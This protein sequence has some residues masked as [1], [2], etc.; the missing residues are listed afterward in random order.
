MASETAPGA[1]YEALLALC[2]R[3]RSVRRF[4]P[5]P[6]PEETV[7]RIL[8]VAR[9]S[10]Y[11]AGKKSWSVK[12]VR[13]PSVLEAMAMAVRRRVEL[14]LP[15]VREEF[16][17]GFGAYAQNFV[18]F[19]SAPLVLVPVFRVSPALSLALALDAPDPDIAVWERDAYLESIACVTMLVLLAAESQGLG[20][21]FMTGPLIAREELRRIVGVPGG[22]EIGAVVPIGFKH[23]T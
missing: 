1:A 2:Q 16:R 3:R 7:A 19:S 6:V 17:E 9:T 23:E 11:A 20:A 18:A 14:L 15:K 21:C 8:E 22:W 5:D 4:H 10:P 13:D 12:V